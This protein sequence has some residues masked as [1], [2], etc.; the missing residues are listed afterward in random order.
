MTD[1][2]WKIEDI[3][4]EADKSVRYVRETLVKLP[5]FPGPLV[6][7]PRGKV[8]SADDVR[9]W[10]R[11][12]RAALAYVRHLSHSLSLWCRIG[13]QLLSGLARCCQGTVYRR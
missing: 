12:P 2:R 11:S 7:M 6:N 13:C 5:S 4:A 1:D 8:W 9:K 3:A 10:L